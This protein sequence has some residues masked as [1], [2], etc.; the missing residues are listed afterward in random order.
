[1]TLF[2][3]FDGVIVDSKKA[4]VNYYNNHYQDKPGFIEADENKCNKWNFSDICPLAIDDVEDIFGQEELFNSLEFFPNAKEILEE[5]NKDYRVIIVSIGTYNNIHHKSKWIKEN[6]PF[7]KESILLAKKTGEMVN[8]S[9]VNMEG[10]IFID[11]VSEN[12]H[13]TNADL[14]LRFGREYSWNEDWNGLRAA[15]WNILNKML[16]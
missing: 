10:S 2:I 11:D 15:N 4:F 8:K 12:L 16:A 13:S 14:K 5:L 1:M 9:L 3:D 7:I 6:L